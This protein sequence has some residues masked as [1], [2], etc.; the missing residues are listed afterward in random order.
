[1]NKADLIEALAKETK[2]SKAAAERS[3]GGFIKTI[4]SG[5]KKDKNV[6]L[7]GFGTFKVVN[8]KARVGR[9]P[10]TGEPIN[11]KASKGVGF[12]AGKGLKSGL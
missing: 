1:M 9:N 8:R 10:R 11:I 3:V 4:K 12:R 6:Q 5:L 7:V 2:S